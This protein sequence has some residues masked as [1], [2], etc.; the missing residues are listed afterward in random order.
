MHMHRVD[1]IDLSNGMKIR[2]PTDKLGKKSFEWNFVFPIFGL[3]FIFKSLGDGSLG[4]PG[5]WRRRIGSGRRTPPTLPFIRIR[6]L[7]IV[8]LI[9]FGWKT[10]AFLCLSLSRSTS[11]EDPHIHKF[12]SDNS[13]GMGL[14]DSNPF[15]GCHRSKGGGR[16]IITTSSLHWQIT[17]GLEFYYSPRLARTPFI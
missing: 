16:R 11:P 10:N 15:R 6:I 1:N 4:L 3:L 8:I 7:S 5:D 13:R 12:R 9:Y 17:I 14:T 2:P